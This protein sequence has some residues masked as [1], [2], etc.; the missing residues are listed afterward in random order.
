MKKRAIIYHNILWSHYKGRVFS[1]IERIQ[2][3]SPSEFSISFIQIAETDSDRKF[4][5]DWTDREASRD[6]FKRGLIVVA[7]LGE[8]RIL[9]IVVWSDGFGKE[10][11]N[12]L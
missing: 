8:S 5:G 3:T 7:G 11:W 1:E 12:V 10:S 9:G 4:I 2:R 6:S